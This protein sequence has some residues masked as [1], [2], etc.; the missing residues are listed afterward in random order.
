MV[1][2]ILYRRTGKKNWLFYCYNNTKSVPNICYKDTPDYDIFLNNT[3]IKIITINRV[4]KDTKSE[5]EEVLLAGD[6]EKKSPTA[7]LSIT[8]AS[9]GI[10]TA[11]AKSSVWEIDN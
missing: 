6:G 3:K 9:N 5:M 2:F 11:I 10:A 8:S 7:L 1:T 4:S